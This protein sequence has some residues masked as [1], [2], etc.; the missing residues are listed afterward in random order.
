MSGAG[1]YSFALDGPAW[2]DVSKGDE[3]LL[4]YSFS[5]DPDCS[6]IRKIVSFDL[7]AGTYQVQTRKSQS[8]KMRSL[9]L[10]N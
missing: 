2:I 5:H 4:P 10:A 1:K 7:A 6:G 8:P 9:I 3:A